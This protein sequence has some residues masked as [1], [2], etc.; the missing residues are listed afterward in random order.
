MQTQTRDEL[1]TSPAL[2]EPLPVEAEPPTPEEQPLQEQPAV[3][4]DPKEAKRIL[5]SLMFPSAMSA[6]IFSMTQIALPALRRDFQIS[7]DMTAW[8]ATTFTLPFMVMMP[9]YGRLGDGVDRR[10]LILMSI[11]IFAVGTLITLFSPSLAWLIT[12]RVIQGLG[13]AGVTPLAM[14]IISNV[15]PNEKNGK[16]LGAWSVI[17]P[18]VGFFAPLVAGFLIERWGWRAAF[19]P[20]LLLAGIAY[21]VVLKKIPNNLNPDKPNFLKHFDWPGVILLASAITALLCYLSSRPITGVE[22]LQ[23]WWLLGVGCLLLGGVLW[24]ERQ[25]EA[26]FIDMALFSYKSFDLASVSGAIRLLVMTGLGFLLPLYLVDVYEL[27]LAYTGGVIMVNAGTMAIVVRYGGKLADWWGS[28]WP[29]ASGLVIQASAL[30]VLFLLPAETPVW[31]VA[32]VM[33][34]NGLGAGLSL[35]ALQQAAMNAIPEAKKGL[36]AGLYNMSCFGGAVIGAAIGGV[37]LHIFLNQGFETLHAYRYTFLFF[38]GMGGVGMVI[39][40]FLPH[41]RPEE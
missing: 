9:V 16:A 15:F 3:D 26:A 38:A 21:A 39:S 19:V 41:C 10:R 22:P 14:A 18:L 8:I 29:C 35:A 11:T 37:L 7:E 17:G 1:R 36:A 27:N 25:R 31:V 30:A 28:R 12:G 13:V 4:L 24:W 6:S 20:P 32:L 33:A 40:F 23:D 5:V 34:Y 2:G